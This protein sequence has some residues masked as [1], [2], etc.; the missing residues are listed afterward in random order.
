V[1]QPLPPRP[2]H[3]PT[4]APADPPS[5]HPAV[6][7]QGAPTPIVPYPHDDAILRYRNQRIVLSGRALHHILWLAA[8]HSAINSIAAESGQIWLTWKGGSIAG[9]IRTRL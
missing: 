7:A 1:N 6:D 9:E 2:A 4:N 8:H 3:A 5:A